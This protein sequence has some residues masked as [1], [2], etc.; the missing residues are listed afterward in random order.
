MLPFNFQLGG[1]GVPLYLAIVPIT[2]KV[3]NPTG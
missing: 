2:T 3:P 1:T